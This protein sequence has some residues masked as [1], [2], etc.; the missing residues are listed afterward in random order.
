MNAKLAARKNAARESNLVQAGMKLIVKQNV[1]AAPIKQNVVTSSV[2]PNVFPTQV[3]PNVVEEVK[4]L[5]GNM[6]ESSQPV[7]DK[8]N[9]SSSIYQLVPFKKGH[10]IAHIPKAMPSAPQQKPAMKRGSCSP[11]DYQSK[12]ILKRVKKDH[13]DNLLTPPSVSPM[14]ID[15]IPENHTAN[16][17]SS[18]VG[19]DASVI[20]NRMFGNRCNAKVL[21]VPAKRFG[22]FITH[23]RLVRMFYTTI[24]LY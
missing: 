2:K 16:L 9:S 14:E 22:D 20:M 21:P 15:E 11:P 17:I 3:K 7:E 18:I 23:E 13:L 10:R 19:W 5:T 24:C 8:N 4:K 12:I 1:V 6:A